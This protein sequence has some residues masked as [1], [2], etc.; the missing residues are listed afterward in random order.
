MVTLIDLTNFVW[1]ITLDETGINIEKITQTYNSKKIE[2]P[3]KQG[4]TRGLVYY[5]QTQKISVS[6]EIDGATGLPAVTFATAV[7][8]ANQTDAAGITTGKTWL[9]ELTLDYSR[10]GLQKL[11]VT[12][13]RYPLVT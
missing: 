12:A 5:D 10:E 1:A 7:T 8:V 3:N 11:S 13:T 9:D 2:V 4:E 6:G